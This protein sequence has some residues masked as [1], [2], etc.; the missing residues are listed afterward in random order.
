MWVPGFPFCCCHHDLTPLGKT[1]FPFRDRVPFYQRTNKS[2]VAKDENVLESRSS[3]FLAKHRPKLLQQRLLF[4]GACTVAGLSCHLKGQPCQPW[5]QGV[6]LD[7]LANC[8]HKQGSLMSCLF[9]KQGPAAVSC[10]GNVYV[11]LV[12]VI[13]CSVCWNA[14]HSRVCT[15]LPSLLSCAKHWG[16]WRKV[17]APP[18]GWRERAEL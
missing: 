1:T 18:E 15:L 9:P 4:S 12:F 10:V 5:G 11:A 14:C 6:A 2:K 16:G 8:Q 7:V 3:A 13:S 17:G